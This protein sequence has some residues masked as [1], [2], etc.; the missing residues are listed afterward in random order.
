M[1][2]FEVLLGLYV[3]FGISNDFVLFHLLFI[4]GNEVANS[5]SKLL[6]F[7]SLLF[8]LLA[9]LVH[10]VHMAT[11]GSDSRGFHIQV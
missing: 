11:M 1:Q 6:I 9:K 7:T 5:E 3:L 2:S 4:V 8:K 10:E